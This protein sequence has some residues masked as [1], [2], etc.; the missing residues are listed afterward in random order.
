MS[1]ASSTSPEFQPIALPG[2]GRAL[3]LSGKLDRTS[4]EAIYRKSQTSRTSF[5]SELSGSGCVSAYDLASTL[6]KVFSAPL[7][8]LDAVDPQQLPKGLLDPKICQDFRLLVIG[9]RNNRLIIATADPSDP[10]A[11]EQIKF[12]TRLGV[13]WVIAEYDK[14]QQWL[15]KHAKPL[16]GRP[17]ARWRIYI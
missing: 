8:D 4:A 16:L 15:A 1:I 5:I 13:D 2:L 9:K 14:L 6:S 3:V 7:L 11:A 10:Q 17:T 12:A